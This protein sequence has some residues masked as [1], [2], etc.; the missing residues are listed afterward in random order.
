M[1]LARI[2]RSRSTS[3]SG[4]EGSS[5]TGR[6]SASV[7]PPVQRRKERDSTP[8]N[9]SSA[10]PPLPEGFLES[11]EVSWELGMAAGVSRRSHRVRAVAMRLLRDHLGNVV[12]GV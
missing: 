2:V 10:S 1:G 12:C 4:S 5:K 11:A 8:H 9:S 7:A 6:P 3:R